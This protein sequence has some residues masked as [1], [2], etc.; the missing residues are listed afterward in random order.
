MN[1]YRSGTSRLLIWLL[2]ILA[3]PV[4]H[5]GTALSLDDPQRIERVME[6]ELAYLGLEK[7]PRSQALVEQAAWL[8]YDVAYR[9]TGIEE[10]TR[11][12]ETK[13]PL[14]RTVMGAW[15]GV[16][17]WVLAMELIFIR[18]AVLVMVLPLLI[19][20]WW[21][22]AWDGWAGWYLRRTV[23]GRESAF[24]YHRTKAGLRHGSIGLI[25][26]Y[27]AAPIALNPTWIFPPLIVTSAL[28]SRYT[29]TYFKKYL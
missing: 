16:W 22:A 12:P 29:V 2:A 5:V 1:R 6:Q 3:I 25:F 7:S 9:Q 26:A 24:I 27:L 20:A 10:L 14:A 23:G 21:L 15:D 17:A 11:D 4:V 28:L 8:G 13:D 18:G 19:L